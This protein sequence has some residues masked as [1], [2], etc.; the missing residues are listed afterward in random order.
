MI[1]LQKRYLS[2]P[3]GPETVAPHQSPRSLRRSLIDFNNRIRAVT[4]T[5]R[6]VYEPMS[7]SPVSSGTPI[8]LKPDPSERFNASPQ[9]QIE[10][11]LSVSSSGGRSRIPVPV[12][13]RANAS[14]ASSVTKSPVP[15]FTSSSSS[16]PVNTTIVQTLMPSVGNAQSND[17]STITAQEGT[18]TVPLFVYPGGDGSS[19]SKLNSLTRSRAFVPTSPDAPVPVGEPCWSD[20]LELKSLV[21]GADSPK[22]KNIA[23]PLP[24]KTPFDSNGDVEYL[25]E[26]QRPET[27]QPLVSGVEELEGDKELHKASLIEA[28]RF[29]E[30]G[31]LIEKTKTYR[32]ESMQRIPNPNLEGRLSVLVYSARNLPETKRLSH[33][34]DPFVQLF[35]ESPNNEHRVCHRTGIQWGNLSPSWVE[36]FVLDVDDLDGALILQVM[37]AHRSGDADFLG[38][39]MV[40]LLQL[41]DQKSH[42]MTLPIDFRGIFG[43]YS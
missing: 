8:T 35:V 21:P 30:M 27:E 16:I 26:D 19:P 38:Q 13:R 31:Q 34:A 5:E 11:P 23:G 43:Y 25:H 41:K 14:P 4:P 32:T 40:E 20:I 17:Q 37:D 18:R 33:S 1:C 36:Q 3:A 39:A 42:S 9:I 24:P 15:L 22:L 7:I 28:V 29:P 6:E 10:T 12:A 2:R